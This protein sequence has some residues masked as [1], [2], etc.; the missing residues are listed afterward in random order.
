MKAKILRELNGESRQ[1]EIDKG[2]ILTIEWDDL[3][4][5]ATAVSDTGVSIARFSF[6]EDRDV[7]TEELRSMKIAHM[8]V[9]KKYQGR[10][11]GRELVRLVKDI[12]QVSI[13]ATM[14]TGNIS[15]DTTELTIEG[16]EFVY[17]LINDG[18]IE[19]FV[20]DFSEEE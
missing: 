7:R 13:W 4:R 12:T 2:E 14:N 6:D 9:E 5:L 3:N 15:I 11:V 1:V 8:D 16:Q 20:N 19:G 17:R 18:L 10:G